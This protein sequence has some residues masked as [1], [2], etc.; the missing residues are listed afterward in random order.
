MLQRYRLP[1]ANLPSLVWP[2][3]QLFKL[4]MT[5]EGATNRLKTETSKMNEIMRE[6]PLA[7]QA[8]AFEMLDEHE[9]SRDYESLSERLLSLE[10]H[11]A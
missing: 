7:V 5:S 1:L 8:N 3:A 6:K 11:N 4:I 10:N 9:E 2:A